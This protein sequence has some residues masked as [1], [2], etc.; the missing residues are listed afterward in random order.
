[1][2]L[3]TPVKTDMKKLKPPHHLGSHTEGER[4]RL[5]EVLSK[6]ALDFL[7][8]AKHKSKLNII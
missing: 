6:H 1:M 5:S 4:I 7:I 3:T 2:N 8:T